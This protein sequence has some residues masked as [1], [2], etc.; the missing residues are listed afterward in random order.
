MSSYTESKIMHS[1]CMYTNPKN[2]SIKQYV[3]IVQLKNGICVQGLVATSG[4]PP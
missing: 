4:S 2:V 1:T 3:C